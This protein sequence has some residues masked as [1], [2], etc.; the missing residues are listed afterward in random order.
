[1]TNKPQDV[2]ANYEA[3][4]DEELVAIHWLDK[5]ATGL[6]NPPDIFTESGLKLMDAVI[7]FWEKHFSQE[8]KDWIHDRK[9]DLDNEKSLSYLA[10]TKSIGYN[11][12]SYPP[13]L[14]KLIKV[15]F[16]D[17]RL[18]DKKV[19]EK[20]IKIYPFFRTSNYA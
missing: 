2:L 5:V 11:P 10:S 1:M 13:T 14:F 9:I 18:Q 4:T 12:V 15:M 16:P 8:A 6:G 19:W 20:L 7:G 3:P 17:M